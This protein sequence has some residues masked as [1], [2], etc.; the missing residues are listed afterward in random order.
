MQ[1]QLSLQTRTLGAAARG[2]ARARPS[3]AAALQAA[4]F[5]GTVL[6]LVLQFMAVVVYDESPWKLLRMFAAM[7]RGRGALEPDDEFDFALVA[8]GLILFYALSMLYGLAAAC[9]L[10]ESPR[11]NASIIGIAFG[12]A[13]Y[14]ANFYGFTALFPWFAGNRTIDTLIAHGLYGLLLARA[15]CAFREGD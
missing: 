8:I 14:G 4:L 2:F 10:T 3:A 13:L 5:A 1:Q 7:A 9:L 6:L 12:L 11:R 15:Y